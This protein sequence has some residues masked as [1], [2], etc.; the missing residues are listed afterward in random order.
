MSTPLSRSDKPFN[1]ETP[2]V[3]LGEQIN[4]PNELFYVRHHLPV[5]HIKAEDYRLSVEGEF[6]LH[7]WSCHYMFRDMVFPEAL[8]AYLVCQVMVQYARLHIERM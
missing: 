3:L 6:G 1:A 7:H 4:T 5:P 2:R 8:P